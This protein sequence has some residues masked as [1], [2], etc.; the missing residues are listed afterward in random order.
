MIGTRAMS[1]S[2]GDQVE[3]RR[4]MACLGVEQAFVHVDVDACWRHP[5]TWSRATAIAVAVARPSLMRRREACAE[6]VTLVRSPTI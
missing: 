4:I 6:P 1:G 5:R 3:E 2:V